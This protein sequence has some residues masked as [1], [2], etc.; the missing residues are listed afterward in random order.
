MT[1]KKV[2]EFEEN[3]EATKAEEKNVLIEGQE[4][5]EESVE[6][7]TENVTIKE[8][9]EKEN[10][11]DVVAKKPYVKPEISIEMKSDVV[12][13][14]DEPNDVEKEEDAETSA[15]EAKVSEEES[16]SQFTA[17]YDLIISKSKEFQR[18]DKGVLTLEKKRTVHTNSD[19]SRENLIQLARAIKFGFPITGSI[20]GVEMPSDKCNTPCAVVYYGDFKVIIPALDCISEPDY[21]G[22][23]KNDYLYAQLNKRLGS[24]IDYII[25]GVNLEERCAIANR[26]EAMKSKRHN[27]YFKHGNENGGK[28]LIFEGVRAESRVVSV[29][30]S[31]VFV[32]VFGTETFIPLKEVCYQRI[33]DA[34]MMYQAGQRILV[35]V[36]E[37]Q[38][39]NNDEV[40]LSASIKQ[41]EDNPFA[42]AC[43]NFTVGCKYVGTV[44]MVNENNVYVALAGGVE[45]LCTIQKY[46]N[47]P[48]RGSKATVVILGIN[49]EANRI[50]GTITHSS[51]TR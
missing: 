50:W 32:E 43:Q 35:R 28:G 36:L 21:K 25:K 20:Q 24:E 12:V 7:Q 23:N 44:T 9:D 3:M 15:H 37:V 19:K 14:E 42:K 6:T 1:T 49:K 22:Q 2:K 47:R 27:Y 40:T 16:E 34:Q 33:L 18:V 26:L 13:I 48:A 17:D 51:V 31:G 8:A 30:K 41:A 11:P 39:G 45:C 10:R 38:K 4:E 29:I 5:N 46:T